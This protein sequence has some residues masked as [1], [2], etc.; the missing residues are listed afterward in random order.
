MT[1]KPVLKHKRSKTQ[2][3]VQME[4]GREKGR[5][6]TGRT[7]RQGAR[8][9]RPVLSERASDSD[10]NTEPKRRGRRGATE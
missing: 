5:I 1:S 2:Q 3:A 4:G 9:Q 8:L 10:Q 6:R 7:T